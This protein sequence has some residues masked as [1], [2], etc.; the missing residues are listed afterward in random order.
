MCQF[1]NGRPEKSRKGNQKR[2]KNTQKIISVPSKL[3]THAEDIKY[4]LLKIKLDDHITGKEVIN[5]SPKGGEYPEKRFW[6]KVQESNIK[7]IIQVYKIDFEM[8]GYSAKKYFDAMGM[9]FL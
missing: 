7:K 6:N 9:N 5:Q 4:F 1:R 8:F 3:E 2:Y